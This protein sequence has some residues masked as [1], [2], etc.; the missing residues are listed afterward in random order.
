MLER[1]SEKLHFGIRDGET[2]AALNANWSWLG[3]FCVFTKGLMSL[4]YAS[5]AY[6]NNKNTVNFQMNFHNTT[7]ANAGEARLLLLISLP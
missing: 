5:A 6:N 7:V 3:R 1:R 2:H 4:L